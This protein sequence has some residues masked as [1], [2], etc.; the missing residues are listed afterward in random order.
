M[1]KNKCKTCNPEVD[2][3]IVHEYRPS[4]WHACDHWA[5]IINRLRIIPRLIVVSYAWI[6]WNT[7][8]WFMGLPDPTSTQ[9]AFVST[10]VGAGAAFFG[11]YV[12]ST[13]NK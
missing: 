10:V 13:G 2:K 12:N 6:F 1:T 4:I 7:A 9:A 5:Q 11:L 8:D 3:N